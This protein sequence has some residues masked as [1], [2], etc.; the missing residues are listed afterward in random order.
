MVKSPV[1]RLGG[2]L[3]LN[4]LAATGSDRPRFGPHFDQ[5]VLTITLQLHLFLPRAVASLAG[6]VREFVMSERLYGLQE[7]P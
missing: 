6:H 4:T 1:F 7:L 2:P 5:V 3:L